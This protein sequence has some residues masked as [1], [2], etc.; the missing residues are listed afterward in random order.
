[1]FNKPKDNRKYYYAGDES[2]LAAPQKNRL[3][4]LG[5]SLAAFIIPPL[6]IAQQANA[7]LLETKQYAILAGYLI[8]VIFTATLGVYCLISALTRARLG[9]PVRLKPRR[10]S[11]GQTDVF[12]RRVVRPPCRRLHACQSRTA[13]IRVFVVVACARGVFRRCGDGSG[14]LP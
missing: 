5:V 12:V 7:K 14:D 13:H 6:I 11:L 3:I 9:K 10:A 8:L 2:S 1:M 4:A